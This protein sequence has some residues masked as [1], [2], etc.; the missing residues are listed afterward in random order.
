MRCATSSKLLLFD[1]FHRV[2]IDASIFWNGDMG[3][4]ALSLLFLPLAEARLPRSKPPPKQGSWQ[5]LAKSEPTPGSLRRVSS[6]ILCSADAAKE[7]DL[8]V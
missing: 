6:L 5:K 2:T 4:S 8:A 1:S 7:G 3:V